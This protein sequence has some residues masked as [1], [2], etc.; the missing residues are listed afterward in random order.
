MGLEVK[1]EWLE[2]LKL[3]FDEGLQ[4]N[5]IAERMYKSERLIRHYW[6]KIQDLL[7]VYPEKGKNL[8]ILT[9]KRAR[10]AGLID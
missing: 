3:A 2:V 5:A 7:E 4:D 1:P 8:R 10:E 6:T 9:L